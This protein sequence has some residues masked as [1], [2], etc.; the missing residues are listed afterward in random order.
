MVEKIIRFVEAHNFTL[1]RSSLF[2]HILQIQVTTNN[3]KIYKGMP[4]SQ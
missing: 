3:G 4:M 1:K 2:I